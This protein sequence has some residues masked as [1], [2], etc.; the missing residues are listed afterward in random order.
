MFNR[1]LKKLIKRP[2]IFF[3]DYLVKKHP[4]LNSELKISEFDENSVSVV[5]KYL[6]DV[7][8]KLPLPS[9]DV[10]IVYTWVNDKDP[11]WLEKKKQ[12]AQEELACAGSADQARFENHNELYY[13]ILSVRK[14]LPW[15][16]NIY[17]VTDNQKPDWLIENDNIY[18]VDHS[19]II[20]S[21]YLP[22][23]NSHVIEAH[24]HKINGLSEHFI[25]F[26]D[27]VFVAKPLE[28]EHFFRKNGICSIFTSHKSLS[29]MEA[30]GIHTATLMASNN[31]NQ[32]LRKYYDITIDVPLVHTYVPLKKSIFYDCWEKNSENI[33]LF[34]SNKYRFNNDLNMAT[35]LVPW[36]MY[37]N[38]HSIISNDICY[39]FNIR[40]NHALNQ[41]EKLLTVKKMGIE[42]HSFC[43]N[44]FKN[45][46]S[47]M[48]CFSKFLEEFLNKYYL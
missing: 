29:E 2:E 13:S 44:D 35:F 46:N 30:R 11:I 42:P 14:F 20:E 1:K 45:E 4:V 17:I 26:N 38:G 47:N 32:L 27:D 34:L 48:K 15:V 37:I 21:Q 39:Y 18:I 6:N 31:S 22:T 9:F 5:E 28:K 33:K 40:S 10:D 43:A 16:R 23:F 24:L 36:M 25:Y 19:D 7:E 12:Y 3:R 41:Y 8:K